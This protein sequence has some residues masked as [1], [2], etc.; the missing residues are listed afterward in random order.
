MKA[1]GLNA[2]S[3]KPIWD[4]IPQAEKDQWAQIAQ[5]LNEEADGVY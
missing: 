1:N 5:H 3:V 2:L 4:K